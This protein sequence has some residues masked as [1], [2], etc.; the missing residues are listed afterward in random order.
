MLSYKPITTK[1]EFLCVIK[2]R[3]V[4]HDEQINK[5]CLNIWI[6][7]IFWTEDTTSQ[8]EGLVNHATIK[9]TTASLFLSNMDSPAQIS[10][11]KR[12]LFQKYQLLKLSKRRMLSDCLT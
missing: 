9:H 3:C 11:Q 4:L 8:T 12:P 2:F 5:A 1:Q 7:I 10:N 6:A